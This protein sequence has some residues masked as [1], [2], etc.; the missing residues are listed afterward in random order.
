VAVVRR[1]HGV[2]LAEDLQAQELGT[3]YCFPSV[4]AGLEYCERAYLQVRHP[5]RVSA[6]RYILGSVFLHL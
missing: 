6:S 2:P 5:D 4:D 1:A 3:C